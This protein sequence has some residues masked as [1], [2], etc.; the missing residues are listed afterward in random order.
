MTLKILKNQLLVATPKIKTHDQFNKSVVYICSNNKESVLGLIINKPTNTNLKAV[1]KQLGINTTRTFSENLEKKVYIG[2]PIE[3]SNLF[4]LHTTRIIKKYF[5]TTKINNDLSIT[6]SIDILN[7]IA[8]NNFPEYFDIYCGYSSWSYEQILSEL[9]Y[10]DWISKPYSS[11][12]L[13][14]HNNNEKWNIC[15]K[16]IGIKDFSRFSLLNEYV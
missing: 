5:T 4:V 9:E 3:M 8:K 1:F 13:F 16:D 6:S 7:D 14:H 10:N 15:I 12:I 11:D 2:G